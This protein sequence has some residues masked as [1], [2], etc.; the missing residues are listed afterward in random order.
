MMFI[1][2]LITLDPDRVS[3]FAADGNC[4]GYYGNG[5]DDE[6]GIITHTR[7]EQHPWWQ[8]DLGE[9][10]EIGTI[11]V[12]LCDDTFMGDETLPTSYLFPLWVFVSN[13]PFGK[14]GLKQAKVG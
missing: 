2:K 12:W 9:E 8:V 5:I 10:R 14:E 7:I 3:S 11:K 6:R 13:V 1:S 4:D